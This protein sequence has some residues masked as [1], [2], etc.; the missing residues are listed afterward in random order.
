[1]GEQE[2]EQNLTVLE[3]LEQQNMSRDEYLSILDKSIANAEKMKE[4]VSSQ[5]FIDLFETMY[6]KDFAVANAQNIS[7][8]KPEVRERIQEKLVARSIFSKFIEQVLNDGDE[9][10]AA[11]IDFRNAEK[12]ELEDGSD[13]ESE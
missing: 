2:M 10:K 1:M 9:A 7:V 12:L 5:N 8:Y 6:I 3:Q 11:M 4:Q 13:S